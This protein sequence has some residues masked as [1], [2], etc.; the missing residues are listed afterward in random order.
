V[1]LFDLLQSPGPDIRAY[2]A[3]RTHALLEEL[4]SVA[5]SK[6][7][8]D[9]VQREIAR[10]NA[11]RSAARRLLALRRGAPRIGGSS[12]VPLLGAFWRMPPEEYATLA[13]DA[14]DDIARGGPLAG[15]RVLLAGSPVD[16]PEL[17]A[18]IES[19]GAI[20]VR[21]TG[22]WGSDIGGYDPD[23]GDDPVTAL[24]DWYRTHA[25]GARTP[26]E[27][28][29]ASLVRA[30]DD[31]DAVVVSLPPDDAV[32]G[33]DYPALRELLDARRIPHACLRGD[34]HAPLSSEDD[35]RLEALVRTAAERAAE[36]KEAPVG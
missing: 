32:F 33:W 21:E 5:D 16:G 14:A 20:V 3:A 36:R 10:T 4:A 7:S 35:G 2:N 24:A 13:G 9:D 18:A 6:P 8:L 29:R 27:V 15:P 17:H 19:H 11:S 26:G 34:P 30:L 1:L 23:G 31:V 25:V 12:V 28:S 22:P